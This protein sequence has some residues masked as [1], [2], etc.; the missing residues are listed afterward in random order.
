M[1]CI[2][3]IFGIMCVIVAI[4]GLCQGVTGKKPRAVNIK[5]DI[6]SGRDMQT[7]RNIALLEEVN[8]PHRD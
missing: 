6:A 3:I 8:R 7:V 2:A 4:S 1:E 5:E